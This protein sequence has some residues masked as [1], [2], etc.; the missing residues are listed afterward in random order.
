MDTYTSQ[1]I[2]N[3]NEWAKAILEIIME[4]DKVFSHEYKSID[5]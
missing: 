2:Q 1:W 4:K 3:Y 5:E